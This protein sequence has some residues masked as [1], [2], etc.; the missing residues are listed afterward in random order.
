MPLHAVCSTV[1]NTISDISGIKLIVNY[2]LEGLYDFSANIRLT[3]R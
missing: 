2:M 3:I 1:N